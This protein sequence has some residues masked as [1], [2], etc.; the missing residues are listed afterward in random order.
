MDNDPGP[1][2]RIYA[3][4]ELNMGI[5]SM[6]VIQADGVRTIV[7]DRLWRRAP[8]A[9]QSAMRTHD[10]D[11]IETLDSL[12][13]LLAGFC[14]A[15]RDYAVCSM[16][17]IISGVDLW[18]DDI[19]RIADEMGIVAL[20]PD[21]RRHADMVLAA[22]EN[23]L[24][25]NNGQRLFIVPGGAE[26]YIISGDGKY[27]Y[28]LPM[29]MDMGQ[30]ANLLEI[31]HEAERRQFKRGARQD[32]QLAVL[33]DEANACA[34]FLSASELSN[35]KLFICANLPNEAIAYGNHTAKQFAHMVDETA[36]HLAKADVQLC[37]ALKGSDICHESF[38]VN[39]LRRAHNAMQIANA[40][41]TRL[42][43]LEVNLV[44]I[45]ATDAIAHALAHSL[46]HIED[47]GH[48]A[49][50]ARRGAK[51]YASAHNGN[52][53]Q[54]DRIITLARLILGAMNCA[55]SESELPLANELIEL[56]SI[57]NDCVLP[58]EA[59]LIRDIDMLPGLGMQT[60]NMLQKI[61][62]V[63]DDAPNEDVLGIICDQSTDAQDDDAL[64]A[65]DSEYS[66]EF[67]PTDDYDS[68]DADAESAIEEA[69][70][71]EKDRTEAPDYSAMALHVPLEMRVAVILYMA[72][73]LNAS[74]RGRYNEFSA[75]LG[76]RGLL[77][78]ATAQ[79]SAI[80]ETLAFKYR[81][82]LFRRFFGIKIRLKPDKRRNR[83]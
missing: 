80:L 7:I 66:D 58:D 68:D 28:K 16:Y 40:V 43:A 62:S 65:G 19:A 59:Q 10:N 67:A 82:E 79:E 34:R 31:V 69:I 45:S 25:G 64:F 14:R 61:C 9:L 32:M 56:A 46:V 70:K 12:R 60:R 1:E 26:T 2:C 8:F 23:I 76:K 75:K 3:I 47:A 4:V 63:G 78:R 24:G 83:Q 49:E 27:S 33:R 81:A 21:W 11:N 74:G 5:A 37:Y 35:Y 17:M 50:L 57:L 20:T 36:H 52:S 53:V 71:L 73:A 55:F 42:G 6:E 41:C 51:N 15:A 13:S 30:S 48:N 44:A 22:A 29:G 54:S 39:C 38:S 77:I 18:R 72:R